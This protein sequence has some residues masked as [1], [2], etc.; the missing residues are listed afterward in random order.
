VPPRGVDQREEYRRVA[1]DS[2]K[3]IGA[4]NVFDCLPP[5]DAG[6]E[7]VGCLPLLLQDRAAWTIAV[8]V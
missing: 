8:P 2:G 3:R 5:L 7:G 6:E 1:D 4:K